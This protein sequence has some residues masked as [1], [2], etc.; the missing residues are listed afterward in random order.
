M[1]KTLHQH[2]DLQCVVHIGGS[3]DK[4]T[5]HFGIATGTHRIQQMLGQFGTRHSLVEVLEVG[6]GEGRQHTHKGF[7]YQMHNVL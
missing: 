4:A 7:R 5:N 3:L 2:I 6:I 1:K